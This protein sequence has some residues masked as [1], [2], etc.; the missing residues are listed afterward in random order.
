MLQ[1]KFF[2]NLH[3]F[4]ISKSILFQ[5]FQISCC[6]ASTIRPPLYMTLCQKVTSLSIYLQ[7]YL[8]R[9][10]FRASRNST[11]VT[12]DVEPV[13]ERLVRILGQIIPLILK[14]SSQYLGLCS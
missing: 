9:F 14:S 12:E 13:K 5:T 4:F 11:N 2:R 8:D 6:D 3:K 1:A 7:F 10:L